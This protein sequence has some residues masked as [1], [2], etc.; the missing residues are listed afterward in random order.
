MDLFSGLTGEVVTLGNPVYEQAR[1]EWNRAIEKFPLAIVYCQ[2]KQDVQ[3]AV[4]WARCHQVP[5]RVR[6]G[7]HSFEGY[8]TGD[9]ALVIDISRM[10]GIKLRNGLLTIEAGVQFQSLYDFLAPLGYPFPGG[11]CPTVGV[12]GYTLGAGWGL[13]ARLL[14]MGCDWLIEAEIV[15]VQG[16]LMTV[17]HACHPD[18]F[19]ALRGAGGGNFG[20]IVTMTFQLPQKVDVVTTVEFFYSNASQQKMA[21]FL[22]AWQKWLKMADTR[23]TIVASLL[24]IRDAGFEIY[25]FGLF[26][27]CRDEAIE[28]TRPLEQVTGGHYEYLQ[29]TLHEAMEAVTEGYP[30]YEMF[31]STGRFVLRPFDEKEISNLAGMIWDVPEGSLLTALTLYAMGGRITALNPYDTAFFYRD[32]L[33]IAGIQSV[34]NDPMY[35]DVNTAWVA[36]KFR[37]LYGITCGSFVNFPYGE[38][39]DYMD[40]YYGGNAQCL[41]YVNKKYD[42]CNVFCFPQCIRG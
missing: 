40:A 36:D 17:N 33:Y 21:D 35:A 9:A 6:G 19:W 31:K 13:S 3:S 8:S 41:Q 11:S 12:A 39:P 27:G 4:K 14:G 7:G 10:N 42:P 34:W 18:L 1:Q 28:A 30:P 23:L 15:N 24:H 38:L 29:G 26:Y 22:G 2:H 20:I 32:A 37:Y 5:I 16:G 25:G